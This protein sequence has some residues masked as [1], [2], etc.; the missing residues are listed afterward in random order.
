MVVLLSHKFLG[1]FVIQQKLTDTYTCEFLKPN[2]LMCNFSFPKFE[3]ETR[4]GLFNAKLL[5]SKP[6]CLGQQNISRD[7]GPFLCSPYGQQGY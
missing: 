2:F 5:P 4:R 1:L 7:E 6:S 3:K